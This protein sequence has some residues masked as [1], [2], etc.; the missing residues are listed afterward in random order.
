[1]RSNSYKTRWSQ[2]LIGSLSFL[3]IAPAQAYQVIPTVNSPEISVDGTLGVRCMAKSGMS[4][5]IY[6]SAGTERGEESVSFGFIIPFHPDKGDCS[7]ILNYEEGL[8]RLSIAERLMERGV[9]SPEEYKAI[10][11]EVYSIIKP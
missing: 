4:P 9:I 10:A 5:S 11:D 2:Y 7:K 6:G 3:L 8:A 1:M